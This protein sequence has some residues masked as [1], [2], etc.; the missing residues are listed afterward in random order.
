MPN[1]KNGGVP[2]PLSDLRKSYV[3]IGCG[4]CYECRKRKRNDWS[5]RLFEEV[6]NSGNEWCFVTFTFNDLSLNKLRNELISR[7]LDYETGEI[8]SDFDKKTDDNAV[9]TLAVRRFLE[10]WRKKYKKSV[11]HFFVTEKGHKGTKRIH[12]HGI[13]KSRNLEDIRKIW[14]YGYIWPRRKHDMAN[15]YVNDKT[16][17]YIV[18]YIT[19]LD[20]VNKDFLPKIL[21]SPGI[22]ASYALTKEF[23]LHKFN[24]EFT[25]D[26]YR[27]KTG[28]KIANPL[29]FRNLLYTDEQKDTLWSYMLDRGERFIFGIKVDVKEKDGW[30]KYFELLALYRIKNKDLGYWTDDDWTLEKYTD[31]LD[32]L[33]LR[34]MVVND[35]FDAISE[36]ID[37]EELEIFKTMRN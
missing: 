31:V 30:N 1:Q 21:C 20:N 25:K 6:K 19:K 23:N 8:S 29:Y 15:N 27:L 16:I 34:N 9:A 33:Q 13:I 10:R 35:S 11:K 28:H 14:G 26:Y 24:N 3:P 2:P 17:N 4:R 36:R 7:H 12:L 37:T 22:G 5:A 32:K 18:K